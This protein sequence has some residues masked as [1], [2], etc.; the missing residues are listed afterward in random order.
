M[1]QKSCAVIFLLVTNS[2]LSFTSASDKKWWEHATIYQIYPRSFQDSNG[3]GIGDLTGI[4]SRLNHLADIGVNTIWMSPMFQ[5]PLK[6]FGYDV[7]DFYNIHDE[8]GTMADFDNFLQ[9]ATSLGIHVL[10][11]FV[12]NHSSDQCEW[13]VQSLLRNPDY[14]EFYTWHNGHEIDGV[15][16]PPNNWKSVFGGS[17]WTYRTERD[18]WYLH[19]FYPEQPDL[20]YR[21]PAVIREMTNVLK[22]WM[23][24]G[25]SGFR[26]DAINHMFEDPNFPDEPRND[27]NNDP[28]SYDY[29]DHIYTKDLPETYEFIYDWRKMLDDFTSENSLPDKIL[30]TEAYANAENTMRYYVS[31][32]GTLG[33]NM[34]FNFQLIYLESGFDARNI[35]GNIDF[36][37]DNMPMGHTPNWVVGS[38]DHKRVASKLGSAFVG[39][40]NTVNL[41][42]PGVSFTYYGE[43]I[44]MEDNY[45]FPISDSRDPN[46]TPMQWDGSVSAGFSTNS[47]TWLPVNN[48]YATINLERLKTLSRS[49]YHHYKELSSLRKEETIID[50]D[51]R[52]KV[53][54]RTL[55]AFTRELPGHP[56][57]LVIVNL[58]GSAVSVNLNNIFLNIPNPLT[59]AASAE[60]SRYRI[61]NEVQSTNI[62]LDGFDALVFRAAYSASSASVKTISLIVSVTVAIKMFIF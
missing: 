10:L 30:M 16:V 11:D 36:W 3:D 58:D 40:L 5:S 18:Q 45:D 43:E 23:Q 28:N 54:S 13:F 57:Y 15:K 38:H 12:P 33:A 9:T 25:V 7:S 53:L 17:A 39:I 44:G 20:N 21:N 4:T 37:L 34:P 31:E 42:L 60:L 26:V 22:F 49:S 48:N 51:I 56:T 62:Q 8:Y 50:G 14:D 35:K 59:V 6:D 1:N 41:M 61:G 47:S 55:F 46:R 52:M 2:L 24:K 32:N 19:Q 29:V 27:W